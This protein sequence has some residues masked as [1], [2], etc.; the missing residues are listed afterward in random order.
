MGSI[1]GGEEKRRAGVES[2][3]MAIDV[4]GL[5]SKRPRQTPTKPLVLCLANPPSPLP[6]YIPLEPSMAAATPR[7]SGLWEYTDMTYSRLSP[8][9]DAEGNEAD[10][11]TPLDRTIDQIGMGALFL[12]ILGP[13]L[14]S[15]NVE[16]SLRHLSM[17][18]PLPLW[19]RCVEIRSMFVRAITEGAFFFFPLGVLSS[20][21]DGR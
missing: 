1:D 14:Q 17:G 6:I 19:F 16:P 4:A 8:H 2:E 7:A 9:D 10:S 5:T 11:R 12:S 18:P 15:L 3:R 20:R 13:S 21:L